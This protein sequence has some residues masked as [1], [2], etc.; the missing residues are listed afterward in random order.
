M[1]IDFTKF[2][3][4][5]V[6]TRGEEEL[7]G[8]Q[9]WRAADYRAEVTSYAIAWFDPVDG[10]TQTRVID[11]PSREKLHHLLA[12]GKKAGY[13]FVT[14]NGAF[15]A[16]WP[17]A[18]GLRHEVSDLHWVDVQLLWKH[19][20]SMP[21]YK[22]QARKEYDLKSAV[23]EFFPQFAGYEDGIDFQSDD[24]E[25]VKRRLQYNTMD[26]VFTLRLLRKF[27][28][29][30]APEQWRQAMIEARSIPLVAGANVDGLAI[31][32]EKINALD[33]KLGQEAA[34]LLADLTGEPGVT[35]EALNSPAQLSKILF[36]VWNLPVLKATDSGGRSTDKEVLHELS[37][38]DPRAQKVRSYRE[39]IGNRGKFVTNIKES[40]AYNGDERVRPQARIYGTY[41]GR[42][43][44]SST[45]GK[46]KGEVQ[47]GFA[48]HQ[49]KRDKLYRSPVIPPPGFKL[50]EFDFAGQEYRWMAVMSKDPTMLALC[51]PGEDPHGYMGAQ[52]AGEQY[53]DLVAAVKAEVP[54][55]KDKR[56]LGKVGNLSCQYRV[57]A[58][59]LLTV[60]RLPPY[61]LDMEIST[62]TL[63]HAAHRQTY[64]MV[65]VYWA[66]QIQLG[67][68]QG[69]I[70]TLGGR[71]VKLP[72]LW[73]DKAVRW[74]LESTCI[75]FPIQGVGADQKYLALA[76]LRDYLPRIGGRF[77]FELHDGLFLLLPE[78]N[79]HDEARK[80]RTLLSNLPYERAWG[81]KL[82]IQFPVDAKVGPSWGALKE[83][84]P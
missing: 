22:N 65:P 76:V 43:T 73:H 63:I 11:K 30:L 21:A 15:D 13:T 37:F 5:D 62:A 8:L 23:R 70:A 18:L 80:I 20:T 40:L 79:A 42:M 49:M 54:G 29:M 16:A 59:K 82:P 78:H 50:A 66:N 56:Q 7:F 74:S 77:Y 53:A 84:E 24:P 12:F 27:H 6:E 64:Q 35:V 68:Q 81:V 9:P 47:T 1:T 61:N 58:P 34:L 51:A 3:A 39:T 72:N 19:A 31:D 32:Q 71:R 25:V 83:L 44:Y 69:Y 2:L 75:N 33:V 45:M 60:A 14:W 67:R 41:T 36:D 38:I 57:S 55:A 4:L 26:A 17:M 10:T 48:L 28:G 52:I 46:N